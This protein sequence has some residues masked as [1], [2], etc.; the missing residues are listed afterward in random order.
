MRQYQGEA[1]IALQ[2]ARQSGDAA[3]APLS[4]GQD[5]GL[6]H[7]IP[8]AAEIVRRIAGEAEEIIAGKLAK[9]VG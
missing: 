6:I 8:P 7:D 1:L 4:M 5:S 2:A 3:E 9:L